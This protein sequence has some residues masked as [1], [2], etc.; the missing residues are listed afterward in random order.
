MDTGL[1]LNQD[2]E[3]IPLKHRGKMQWCVEKPDSEESL[4]F[5]TLDPAFQ[6][7]GSCVFVENTTIVSLN[8]NLCQFPWGYPTVFV[9]F[10]DSAAAS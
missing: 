3:I 10:T 5:I 7:R 8:L 4:L 1:E 6:D 9:V 2:K